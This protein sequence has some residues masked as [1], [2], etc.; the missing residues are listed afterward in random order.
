MVAAFLAATPIKHFDVAASFMA[1][2]RPGEA[3]FVGVLFSPT[4]PDVHI[5]EIPPPRLELEAGQKILI[6]KQPKPPASE[7]EMDPDLTKYLDLSRPVKFPVA[8]ARGAGSGTHPVRA[9]VI[10]FYCSKREGWC[11]R[12]TESLELSVDIP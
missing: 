4:D 2:S 5:N 9:R 6:D 10:F 8:I 12:G 7:K 11:R 1:P 3:P